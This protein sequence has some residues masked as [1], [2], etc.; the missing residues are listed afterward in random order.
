MRCRE[1][2]SSIRKTRKKNEFVSEA[3]LKNQRRD[4]L[5]C[6]FTL[7]FGYRTFFTK[8]PSFFYQKIKKLTYCI[9]SHSSAFFL[10]CTNF[11]PKATFPYHSFK[12]STAS[13]SKGCNLAIF[14]RKS[15][16]L[17]FRTFKTLS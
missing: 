17:I 15:L 11:L 9:V 13:L 16:I 5:F 8:I 4:L 14:I 12:F 10:I 1:F 7:Y 6:I 2:L 3:F